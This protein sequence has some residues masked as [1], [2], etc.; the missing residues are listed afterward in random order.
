MLAPRPGRDGDGPAGDDGML[1]HNGHGRP[2]G[3]VRAEGRLSD[4][5]LDIRF[6][7]DA[8]Q[9]FVLRSALGGVATAQDFDLDELSDLRMAVDELASTLLQLAEAG[10]TF[11][12]E[13]RVYGA[14]LDI[15]ATATASPGAKVDQHT[16]GWHVLTALTDTADSWST[17]DPSGPA[18]RRLHIKATKSAGGGPE[19]PAVADVPGSVG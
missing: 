18:R 14:R 8:R 2:D 16:F 4:C 6:P 13:F 7:A 9:L 12:C 19:Q 17:A 3:T 1:G 11:R 10:S 15:H 5:L